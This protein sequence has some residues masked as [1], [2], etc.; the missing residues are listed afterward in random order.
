VEGNTT[1]LSDYCHIWELGQSKAVQP[2]LYMDVN[3]LVVVLLYTH[4]PG[5]PMLNICGD[6]QHFKFIK[7]A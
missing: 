2:W 7:K 5:S 4:I 1:F 3:V 6:F